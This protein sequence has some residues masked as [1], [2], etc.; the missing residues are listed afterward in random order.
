MV[1]TS[2]LSFTFNFSQ[3]IFQDSS[4]LMVYNDVLNDS[5]L[6]YTDI[7]LEIRE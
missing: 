6:H 1:K 7:L 4:I 2:N 3:L 5:N